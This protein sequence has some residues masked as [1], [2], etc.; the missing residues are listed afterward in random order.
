MAGGTVRALTLAGL[1]SVAGAAQAQDAVSVAPGIYRKVLEND[2][3]RVLEATFKPGAKATVHSHPEHILYMIS[4]GILVLKPAG[5]TG[6][7]MTFKPGEAL[8][9]PAQTRA[10]ENDGDKTVRA[11][12]VELK[13]A[14][15][16]AAAKGKAKR[17]AKKVRRGKR[18]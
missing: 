9:L 3:V 10:T 17:A 14:R 6:Y 8:F 12:I 5:R 11:V 1:V 7:E 13:A 4:D 15:P 16:V 18:K 2:R